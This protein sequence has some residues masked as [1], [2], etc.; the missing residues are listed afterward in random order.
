MTLYLYKLQGLSAAETVDPLSPIC[1]IYE[2]RHMGFTGASLIRSRF[3]G[4]VAV[5]QRARL[6]SLC[7]KAVAKNAREQRDGH[8]S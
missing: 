2:M 4:T 8:Y 5:V 3:L 6:G 7:W 1:I